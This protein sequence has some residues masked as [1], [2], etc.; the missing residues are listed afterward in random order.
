MI[1]ITFIFLLLLSRLFV[2]EVIMGEKLVSHAVDQWTRELPVKAVRGEIADVNGVTLAGNGQSYAVFVRKRCVT[3]ETLCAEVLSETLGLERDAVYKRLTETKSSEITIARQVSKEAVERLSDFDVAGVYYASD[4][5]R[6]YPYDETL[7]S[8]L[9]TISGDG[10]GIY[11]LEK[12]YDKYLSGADGDFLYEADL[13]GKDLE[14]KKPSYVAATDGFNVRLNIDMEIQK[15]CEATLEKARAMYTP[16]SASIIVV[17]PKTGAILAAA[18]TPTYSLNSPP[19]DDISAFNAAIRS[20]LIV[21]SYEPGST[22]KTVTAAAEIEEY[23]LGNPKALPLDHVFDSDRYRVVGGRKIKCWSTHANGKHANQTLKEALNN[24]CNP[25]FVDIALSLGKEKMYDYI[26]K[27]NFGKV[28]GVDFP[29]EAS[30]MVLPLSAVTDGDIA[31]ISFGQTVAVTPLQLAMSTAALVNGGIYY[32]PR[33]ALSVTDGDGNAVES[34]PPRSKGRVISEQASKTLASYLEQVVAVGSGNKAY[35]EGYRVGGKT[36]TA[37]KYENGVIA[38]GKY[39]MSFIGFFPS[40]DPKYLALC[41]VD[42]PIGGK[43]GSTVAAPL[44]KE[45]FEKIISAK[46][47]KPFE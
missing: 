34:F 31:R 4:N 10:V 13:V 41:V 40:F 16:K 1:A 23:L 8:I 5:V 26:E 43:Y 9:G 33:F 38:Q 24:S 19:K 47:I 12:Y 45:V 11:G 44:V 14:G 21:D 3:D 7:F 20:P 6:V 17:A 28:T 30:G 27:L 29:G 2:V 25:C 37:Q 42:E 32:V 22:F 18:T 46:K 15:I 36:G 39:V 35:I